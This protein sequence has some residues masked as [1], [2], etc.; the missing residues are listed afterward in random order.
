[1]ARPRRATR[2]AIAVAVALAAAVIAAAAGT[3][4]YARLVAGFEFQR[5]LGFQEL[6]GGRFLVTDGGGADFTDA[7]SSVFIV[8]RGG[9]VSWRA[10]AGLRF[11]HSAVLL[12][13]G[14]ALVPDTNGDRLVEIAPD[15]S[16]AWT[17]ESWGGG[18]GTLANGV[19]LDYPNHAT[20]LEGGRFLVSSRYGSAVIETDRTGEVYW[21]YYGATRQHA[22]RRLPG[23]TTLIADSDRDRVIEVAPDG[24][25]VWSYGEGLSWPRFAQRLANGDTLITDSGNDRVVEVT[26]DGEIAFEYGRGELSAPYQA[27][28]LAGGTIMIAD[29]QHG[30]LVEI[31]REGRVLWTF[32]R[33]RP[34]RRWL[35]MPSRLANGGAERADRSGR[36]AG[37]RACDL[38]A[39][40]GADWYRDAYDAR[41]GTASFAIRASLPGDDNRFWGQFVRAPREGTAVLR[42]W[43]SAEGVAVG[44]GVGVTFVDRRGGLIGGTSSKPISGDAGW[45]ELVAIAEIPEGTAAVGVTLS[46]IGPGL[47]RWDDVTLRVLEPREADRP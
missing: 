13:N 36:P 18:A 19:R 17:S 8:D 42:A 38:L 43:A 31:D 29:A 3:L 20:E 28:E 9:R 23:G 15:G 37:W 40:D 32:S 21:E 6:P 47:A 16:I 30:R 12:S 1:M 7:G 27:E 25:I 33:K 4:A 22:P 41:S 26:P 10:E 34:L 46:L 11:A 45:T 2:R 24:G 39:P 44:A 35:A 5:A 14:N